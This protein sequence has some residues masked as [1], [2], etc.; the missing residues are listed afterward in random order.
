[1]QIPKTAFLPKARTYRNYSIVM[2]LKLMY[3]K[4]P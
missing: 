1:M 4:P 2:E 3:S